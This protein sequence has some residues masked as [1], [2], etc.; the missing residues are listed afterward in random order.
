MSERGYRGFWGLETGTA[1]EEL[2][3]FLSWK[4]D[5]WVEF[6]RWLDILEQRDRMKKKKLKRQTLRERL[7]KLVRREAVQTKL[8]NGKLM[9]KLTND[10]WRFARAKKIKSVVAPCKSGYCFVTFD[11]P[12]NNRHARNAFR[13]FLKQG[14]F[15]QLQ[16]SVWVHRRD[17]TALVAAV[18]DELGIRPWVTV[19][20]G[21]LVISAFK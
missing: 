1:L 14:G 3:D 20:E 21:K 12:E 17:V 2:A 5:D 9:V 11:I 16:K 19:V 10:G 6:T 7:C 4:K 15:E 8:V 18:V 13:Q